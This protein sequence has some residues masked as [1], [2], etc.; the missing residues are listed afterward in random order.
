MRP[1]PSR[2]L[3]FFR[4]TASSARDAW[5]AVEAIAQV[6]RPTSRCR[7]DFKAESR[8]GAFD[9]V[10]TVYRTFDSFKLTGHIDADLLDAMPKSIKFICHTGLSKRLLVL[11]PFF[12]LHHFH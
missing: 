6:I 12:P 3:L 7:E 4:L 11:L 10:S 9:G 1:E 8:S 2:G 5:S